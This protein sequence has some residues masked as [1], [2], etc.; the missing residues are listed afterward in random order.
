MKEKF[1][2]CSL[3][4]I[5]CHQMKYGTSLNKNWRSYHKTRST[6]IQSNYKQEYQPPLD[7]IK[8]NEKI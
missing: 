6:Y 2:G 3:A 5:E 4:G 8:R 1:R 7:I